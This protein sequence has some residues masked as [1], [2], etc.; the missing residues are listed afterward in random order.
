MDN[1]ESFNLLCSNFLSEISYYFL[2]KPLKVRK[3]GQEL[4]IRSCLPHLEIWVNS[5]LLGSPEYPGV[6]APA[7]KWASLLKTMPTRGGKSHTSTRHIYIY[8]HAWTYR[9]MQRLHSFY[10]KVIIRWVFVEKIYKVLLLNQVVCLMQSK[11][12]MLRC[13]DFQQRKDLFIRQPRGKTGEHV[14]DL[15]PR[16]W[17][18][19]DIY[20]INMKNTE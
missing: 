2:K 19:W 11:T 10:F 17:R 9:Q 16:K 12:K 1:I 20:R 13:W 3:S 18:A 5:S 6:T 8:R 14:S 7:R 15:L 4:T